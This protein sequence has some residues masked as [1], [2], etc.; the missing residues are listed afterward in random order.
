M[1]ISIV[2]GTRPNLI[3]ISPLAKKLARDGQIELQLIDTRQHYDY[4]LDGVFIKELGIP[5]P[6]FLDAG[7]GSHGEQTG[8]ALI[9]IE[10]ELLKFWPDIVLVIGDTNSTLAGALAAVKSG[11]PLG[12]IE[13]G[14]RSFDRKMPEEIN[15]VAVD[16]I[17][18][19]LFA[20]TEIAVKNLKKEGIPKERIFFTYDISVDACL[21]NYEKA[22]KSQVLKEMGIKG[23]FVLVTLHRPANVDNRKILSA[24]LDSL[25]KVSKSKQVIFPLHPRTKKRLEEFGLMKKFS[26]AIKFVKPQGYFE[27]LKLL[28]SASCVVTDSGGVQKEALI[29]GTPCVTV[30]NTTEWPETLKLGANVL[31]GPEGIYD[32]TIK[33]SSREFRNF[34]QGLKNPYGDGKAAE[35]MVRILKK[36]K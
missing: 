32:E 20:P 5:K 35:R 16:H 3:K 27:F 22:K 36:M 24:I 14:L 29:L 4:E 21:G 15:R 30:R 10:K 26:K 19:L 18:D 11:I 17:A 28:S 9:K 6:I 23:G 1:K 31:V 12:H 8:K 33:R 25:E 13:A 7:S 34:M 2:V